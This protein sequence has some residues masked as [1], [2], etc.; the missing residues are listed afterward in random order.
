MT[1][2]V[3][4]GLEDVRVS[5][6]GVMVQVNANIKMPIQILP[7][8]TVVVHVQDLATVAADNNSFNHGSIT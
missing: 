2:D 3:A 5:S 6:L 7:G 8:V 4:E 1:D